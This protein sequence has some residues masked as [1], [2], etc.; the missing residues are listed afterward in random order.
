MEDG[1]NWPN[2]SD[3]GSENDWISFVYEPLIY[4][5]GPKQINPFPLSMQPCLRATTEVLSVTGLVTN[6][7]YAKIMNSM[8]SWKSY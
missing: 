6:K 2:T 5:W 4:S 3:F 8:N 7:K 1:A